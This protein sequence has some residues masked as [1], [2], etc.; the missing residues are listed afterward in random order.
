MVHV[1]VILQITNTEKTCHS[2]IKIYYT[3]CTHTQTI[4]CR[5]ISPLHRLSVISLIGKKY[6][7]A[8]AY[9]II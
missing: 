2:C 6:Q 1:K 5:T 3:N 4:H 8:A 7:T 9:T